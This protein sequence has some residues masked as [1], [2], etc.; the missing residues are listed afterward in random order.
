MNIADFKII[1][2][3]ATVKQSSLRA[4]KGYVVTDKTFKHCFLSFPKIE[5]FAK[6]QI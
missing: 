5:T 4:I 6:P 3:I 2:N 1:R